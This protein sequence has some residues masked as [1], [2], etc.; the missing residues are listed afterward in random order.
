[1]LIIYYL[2][3]ENTNKNYYDKYDRDFEIVFNIVSNI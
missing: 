3:F 2:A 1:M